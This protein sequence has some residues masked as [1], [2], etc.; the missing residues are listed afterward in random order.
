MNFIESMEVGF[1]CRIWA[2][3]VLALLASCAGLPGKIEK[4]ML[5]NDFPRALAELEEEGV[6][7][8]VRGTP[9]PELL[10]A[11]EIYARGVQN[12]Y[13]NRIQRALDSGHA[14][15]SLNLAREA[16]A[17]CPWSP[18]VQDLVDKAGTTVARLNGVRQNWQG[19][20]DQEG[21]PVETARAFMGDLGADT[22]LLSDFPVLSGLKERAVA[23]IVAH[24]ASV[25]ED[26]GRAFGQVDVFREEMV[27]LGCGIGRDHHIFRALD[28][29]GRLPGKKPSQNQMT[30]DDTGSSAFY[31]VVEYL[32]TD[33]DDA[34]LALAPCREGIAWI[35]E[36]WRRREFA[37]ILAN[38]TPGFDAL[39]AGEFLLVQMPPPGP[40]FK[41]QLARAHLNYARKKSGQ[42]REAL[43]AR[44]SLKRAQILNVGGFNSRDFQ[45]I[46]RRAQASLEGSPVD[47]ATLAL[48]P[49]TQGDPVLMD[50]LGSLLFHQLEAGSRRFLWDWMGE[51]PDAPGDV[52]LR[53]HRFDC[54]LPAAA[55]LDRV[56][57]SYLSHQEE[58]PNP[59]FIPNSTSLAARSGR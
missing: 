11:R 49:A 35:F 15:Q 39:C 38:P 23:A 19:R 40:E 13:W 47:H 34:L 51:N 1:R 58:R 53:I 44:I 54:L 48:S 28:G 31:A 25:V 9:E 36:Q 50:L 37:R 2:V 5:E 12:H 29:L 6:G 57:S 18:A 30:L 27:G 4:R 46:H 32:A 26:Q 7:I 17:L 41:S 21:F 16:R 52:Q 56:R 33:A 22:R 45:S 42:G 59:A 24:W 10:Q 3:M 14:R 55:D 8:V 43:L 20:T